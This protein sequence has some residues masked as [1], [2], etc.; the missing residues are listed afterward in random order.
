MPNH[1]SYVFDPITNTYAF[2]TK[3]SILYRIAFLI[4]STFSSISQKEIPNVYQVVIEKVNDEVEPFDISVSKTIIHIIA[5]FFKNVQNS[6]IFIC[7]DDQ[8]KARIRFS[9]F[10]KWYKSS[11]YQEMIAKIDQ[12]ICVNAVDNQ[13][14]KIYTSLLV[15]RSNP[16]YTTLVHV[17]QQIEKILNEEK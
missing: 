11:A 1:Y 15:H 10:N 14:Q 13:I 12:V 5:Q 17:Y 3:N 9:A 7:S 8:D 6:L 16:D 2:I 4:D